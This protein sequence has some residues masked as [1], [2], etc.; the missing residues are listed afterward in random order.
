MTPGPVFLEVYQVKKEL[1]QLWR[2]S[3]LGTVKTYGAGE[4]PSCG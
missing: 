3:F 1:V 2:I 4:D